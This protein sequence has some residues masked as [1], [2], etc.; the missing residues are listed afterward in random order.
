MTRVWKI[1]GATATCLVVTVIPS[2]MLA[3]AA[4]L[5]VDAG[6]LQVWTVES[7]AGPEDSVCGSVD[8][9]AG[10]LTAEPGIALSAPSEPS[11]KNRGWILVGTGGPDTL[12]GSVQNDCLIGGGGDDLLIGGNGQ[13]ILA[14]GAGNDTLFG[15]AGRDLLLGGNGED[16]LDGGQGPD[17]LYAGEGEDVCVS[18]RA[19]DLLDCETTQVDE[20][21]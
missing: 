18:T 4:E 2:L 9:Y 10:V 16:H 12:T 14:G 17:T 11:G 1:L 7:P 13:D 3:H 15:G 5:K 6:V 19:P 8:D 20:A 21:P